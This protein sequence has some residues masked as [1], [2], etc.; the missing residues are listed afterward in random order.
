MVDLG[1]G[2]IFYAVDLK[3][4]AGLFGVSFAQLNPDPTSAQ[5]PG[6]NAGR[7]AS[8]KRVQD[9]VARTAAGLDNPVQDR[10]GHLTPVP[11]FPFFERTAHPGDVPTV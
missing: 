11:T 1:F 3:S 10:F 6:D 8:A 7:T 2:S 5:L 9:Q 4:S